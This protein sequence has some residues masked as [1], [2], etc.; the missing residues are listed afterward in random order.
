MFSLTS[1]AALEFARHKT[2]SLV[3]VAY[4]FDETRRSV[5]DLLTAH[6][7]VLCAVVIE[8]WDS[9]KDR[10]TSTG[11]AFLLQKEHRGKQFNQRVAGFDRCGWVNVSPLR[12]YFLT[13]YS[14][15]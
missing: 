3:T 10:E 12:F 11:S 9:N 15:R 1:F 5:S 8:P 4:Q 7:S 14:R 2:D 6:G 13:V